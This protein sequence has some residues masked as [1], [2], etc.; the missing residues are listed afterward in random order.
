[1]EGASVAGDVIRVLVA[2][3]DVTSGPTWRFLDLA[4]GTG[5]VWGWRVGK[6]RAIEYFVQAVDRAGNVAVSTN[7]GLL[8]AGAPPPELPPAGGGVEPLISPSVGGTQIAG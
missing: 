2:F 4:R 8:F 3:R 6:R 5:S 1:V 7:K